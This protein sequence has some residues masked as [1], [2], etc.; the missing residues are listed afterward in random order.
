MLT[1]IIWRLNG[2]FFFCFNGTFFCLINSGATNILSLSGL[3]GWWLK[4]LNLFSHVLRYIIHAS[5]NSSSLNG[6]LIGV[7]FAY[8]FL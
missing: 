2:T 8:T 6:E 1:I 5:I 4:D 3:C 7:L